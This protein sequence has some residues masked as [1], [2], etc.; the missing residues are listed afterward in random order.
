MLLTPCLASLA[1]PVAALF[2][3]GTVAYYLMFAM[4]AWLFALFVYYTV[5]LM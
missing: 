4:A 1:V 2:L 3:G 5:K